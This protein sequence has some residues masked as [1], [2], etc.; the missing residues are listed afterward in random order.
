[1]RKNNESNSSSTE[2]QLD[3]TPTYAEVTKNETDEGAA[4]MKENALY[5]ST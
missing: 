4:Y 2:D 1:M 3:E 5:G